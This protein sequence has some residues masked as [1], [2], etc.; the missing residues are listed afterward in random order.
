[1]TEFNQNLTSDQLLV[2]APD[3][4]LHVRNRQ[5]IFIQMREESIV[6][7]DRVLAILQAFMKP[8]S[9][10][11]A[12]AQLNAS[13]AS[14][15][16]W[17]DLM[18]MILLLHESGV[19]V[20]PSAVQPHI[21]GSTG[22]DNALIHIAML[23]DRQRTQSY[24]DA[25]REVVQPGDV[26]VDL[27]TG[28]GVL[29]IAAAQAGASRVYAIERGSIGEVAQLNFSAN[30]VDDRITLV[31]GRSTQV[32]LPERADVLVSEIIG[33]EPLRE[34]ILE[35]TADAIERFLKPDAR[36][37]PAQ[38]NLYFQPFTHPDEFQQKYF[39]AE[40]VVDN[41]RSW[42][43]IDFSAMLSVTAPQ[44]FPIMLKATKP[45]AWDLLCD[46]ALLATIDL[47]VQTRSDVELTQTF[48]IQRPGRLD[49]I[50]IYPVAQLSPTVSLTRN[51][52]EVDE[53]SSWFTPIWMLPEP[54]DAQVGDQFQF[55]YRYPM[56]GGSSEISVT[57][58]T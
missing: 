39:F 49:S 22:F 30:Q 23:N 36:L 28:T 14:K 48:T 53:T 17:I 4:D 44:P 31:R 11:A 12:A 7:D 54:F 6:G 27:G 52:Y 20:D 10:K 25:I 43:G 21:S 56:G 19:L 16:D 51:P 41:W 29:A 34:R 47:T 35:F 46:P 40:P 26:V 2:C 42:Y 45:R 37:I 33:A 13:V 18:N 1:M 8:S 57:R 32:N 5:E 58:L 55:T 50:L 24:L 38:M 9:L 3:L 15:H